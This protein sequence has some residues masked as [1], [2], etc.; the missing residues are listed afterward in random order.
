MNKFTFTIL[1][2]LLLFL[3]HTRVP[4]FFY[5]QPYYSTFNNNNENSNYND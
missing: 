2:S 3:A 4:Q 1:I 5:P